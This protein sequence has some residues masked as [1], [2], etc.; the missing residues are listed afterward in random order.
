MS[1][2]APM[3]VLKR[4]WLVVALVTAVALAGT[5]AGLAVAG[6]TYTATATLQVI[7]TSVQPQDLDYTDR[8][9][10]TDKRIAEGASLRAAVRRRFPDVGDVPVSVEPQPNTQLINLSA[11]DDRPEVAQRA[12][13]VWAEALVERVQ[14]RS[15]RAQSAIRERVAT[16][17]AEIENRLAKMREELA[18]ARDPARRARLATSVRVRELGYRA[19]AEQASALDLATDAR[20]TLSIADPASRPSGGAWSN[21][22]RNVALG[23]LLGFAAGVGVAFLL[24][25]RAPQLDTLDDIERATGASVFATIPPLRDE[26]S[27]VFNGSTGEQQAFG[28][29]RARLLSLE[30]STVPR[31]VLVTSAQEGD[32]KSVIAVNLAAALA[33]ARRRTLLVDGD[34]RRP[35]LHRFFGLDNDR[36]LRELLEQEKARVDELASLISDTTVPN[37]S[38]LTSG[39]PSPDAAEL[40]ASP[41]MTEV[42]PLLKRVK[43]PYEFIVIDSPG[44]TA[45]SDAAALA[46]QV[47]VVMFVVGGTPV[48][49]EIVRGARHQL[50]GAGTLSVGVVVNRWLGERSTRYGGD[51]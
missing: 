1:S 23:L 10:N 24:E 15:Y 36:G 28:N 41:R 20:T 4:R 7:S 35:S 19:L 42:I 2:W 3:N 29:L 9:V 33:R 18:A 27:A 38:V 12:A 45:A 5:L 21:V 49:D 16:Q 25:R 40:L 13:N 48:S 51:T 31:S 39:P 44:L 11:R 26:V 22:E 6:P 37:L 43:G 47:D 46:T 32:G 34:L 50:N 14:G 8:L 17:L 30:P